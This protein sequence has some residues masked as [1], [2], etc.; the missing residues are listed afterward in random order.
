MTVLRIMYIVVPTI[1]HFQFNNFNNLINK[2]IM[3]LN[4]LYLQLWD[5]FQGTQ[6]RVRNNRGKRAISVPATEGLL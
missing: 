2:K 3:T 5:F 6:E 1:Y 4:N